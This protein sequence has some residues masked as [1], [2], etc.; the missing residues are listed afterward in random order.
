MASLLVLRTDPLA[1]S[2][3]FDAIETVIVKGQVIRR[4]TLSA[5][6]R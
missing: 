6:A 1:S 2:A 4:E 5:T 3:A